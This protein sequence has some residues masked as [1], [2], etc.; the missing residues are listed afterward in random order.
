ML[1]VVNI[2][3]TSP[4]CQGNSPLSALTPPTILPLF[5]TPHS[6]LGD[7]DGD[8]DGDGGGGVGLGQGIKKQRHPMQ[9]DRLETLR[10]NEKSDIL[11][12]M[13]GLGLSQGNKNII[14]PFFVNIYLMSN[15]CFLSSMFL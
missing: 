15:T 5:L 2:Y 1:Y 13:T 9:F 4:T 3:L 6:Q 8:G 11:I 12:M 10:I 7:G 14:S